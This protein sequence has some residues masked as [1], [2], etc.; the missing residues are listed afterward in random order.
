MILVHPPVSKPGEPPAGIARLSGALKFHGI[1]HS[2]LDANLE[3]LLYLLK[4]PRPDNAGDVWSGRSFRNLDNNLRLIKN[5]ETYLKMDR[6]KRVVRDLGRVLEK[7]SQAGGADVGLANYQQDGLS[8]LRS[9]DLIASSER[10]VRNI[11]Y[12]YFSARLAGI[13]HREQPQWIGFSLNYLSQAICAFAMI[14]FVRREFP[15]I[16]IVAGGGLVTS[17]VNSPLWKDQFKGIIDHLVAGPGEK[18][19]LSLFGVFDKENN[20][21]PDYRTLPD[22]EYL[23]PGVILPYSASTGCY[24]NRCSFC[25]EKAEGSRYIPVPPQTVISDLEMLNV[26]SSPMLVHFLDSALSP[27]M[28]DTLIEKS[29]GIPWYGFA[30]VDKR[31][32]EYGFCRQLKKSGCVMLKLGLE[33]GDQGVLDDMVKGLSVEMSRKALKAL[34][35]AGIA[36]YV[37]LLFGTPSETP[38]SARKTLEFTAA[39]SENI[40]F[41]NLAVFNMPLAASGFYGLK[42]RFFYDADLSLYT[43]FSH[44]AGW[45]RREVKKFLDNEFRRH[46]AIAGILKNDPPVFTSNHAPF[47]VGKTPAGSLLS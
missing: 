29:P 42:T 15:D 12:P 9:A 3:G 16:K 44:P 6:Y 10:F 34:K 32:T 11:F 41:L 37:Y 2:L 24:W 20:Y 26:S 13:I 35:K 47:F 19:L 40:D 1:K 25:P 23:S 38:G 33:S 36:T 31:L 43:D 4:S 17:W 8:P 5:P 30:R 14:G 46:R 21:T 28:M 7:V 45:G 18:Q 27:S 22:G 39:N